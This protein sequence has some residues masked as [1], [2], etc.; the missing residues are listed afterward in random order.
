MNTRTHIHFCSF[1]FGSKIMEQ[2]VNGTNNHYEMSKA[3]S[4]RTNND[5]GLA[6]SD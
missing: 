1:N 4:D 5:Y 3:K 6:E 2:K